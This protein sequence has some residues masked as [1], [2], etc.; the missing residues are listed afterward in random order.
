MRFTVDVDM[1][2]ERLDRVVALR[3]SVSRSVARSLVESGA[4]SVEGQV[5]HQPRF[6]V[7]PGDVI[8]FESA[9]PVPRLMPEAVELDIVFGDDHLLVIDKPAG[10][11]V[12]PGAGTETGTLAAGL[13]RLHPEVEGVGDEGRWGIVHRLDRD[14]SGLIVVALDQESHDGLSGQV[15]ARSMERTY[16]ALVD[17]EFEVPTGTVDAPLGRDP[18]RPIR[19]RVTADGRPARTHY[20]LTEWFPADGVSLLSI[21]LETGRTHQIRVHMAAIGHPL[22]GDSMYRP[23]PDRIEAPR[24]CLHASALAFDHPTKGGRLAFRAELPDD[25][26]VVLERLRQKGSDLSP[27]AG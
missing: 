25:L 13:L 23:G 1:A 2:G 19:W 21:R 11:V 8:V 18:S 4:V 10:M 5:R 16:M 14:T 15:R 7:S 27:G 3:G 9:A 12:H 22:V 20:A 17:G 24:I 6:K 26:A